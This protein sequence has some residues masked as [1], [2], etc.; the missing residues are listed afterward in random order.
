MEYRNGGGMEG[1]ARKAVMQKLKKC[2]LCGR[3]CRGRTAIRNRINGGELKICDKC[4]GK[5]QFKK[6]VTDS[7]T[8]NKGKRGNL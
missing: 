6:D 7:D 1:N 5:Y 4:M 2:E 3:P 8:E